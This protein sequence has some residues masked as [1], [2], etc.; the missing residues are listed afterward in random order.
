MSTD[1]YKA[2]SLDAQ[3]EYDSYLWDLAY[4][5]YLDAKAESEAQYEPEN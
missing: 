5:I 3:A 2:L 1:E 4:D